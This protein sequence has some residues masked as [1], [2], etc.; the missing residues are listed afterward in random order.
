MSPQKAIFRKREFFKIFRICEFWST[1]YF[2]IETEIMKIFRPSDFEHFGSFGCIWRRKKTW[3][4]IFLFLFR[5]PLVQK[6]TS[7]SHVLVP[8]F[9]NFWNFSKIYFYERWKPLRT[10]L[11]FKVSAEEDEE[12][13]SWITRTRANHHSGKVSKILQ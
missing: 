1:S 5:F 2:S 13:L 3:R 8:N 9:Q 10:F 6:K 11:D 7:I 12:E 4:T